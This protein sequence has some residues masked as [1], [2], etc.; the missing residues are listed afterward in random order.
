MIWNDVAWPVRYIYKGGG[1]HV[2]SSFL[3]FL[4]P[5][6]TQSWVRH[7]SVQFCL[8]TRCRWGRLFGLIWRGANGLGPQFLP[9]MKTSRT[10][11]SLIPTW[12]LCGSLLTFTS[13]KKPRQSR[14]RSSSPGRTLTVAPV[15][16]SCNGLQTPGNRRS[17][18]TKSTRSCRRTNDC[19]IS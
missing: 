1:E 4:L 17:S 19:L 14:P 12:W 5:S 15:M 16:R 6:S 7:L 3:S 11:S 13:N 8:H 18:M 10:P 2:F 9:G